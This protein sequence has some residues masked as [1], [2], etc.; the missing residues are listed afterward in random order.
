MRMLPLIAQRL[1]PIGAL[2]F[3]ALT[4]FSET[5]SNAPSGTT[6]AH[7]DGVLSKRPVTFYKDVIPIAQ[8]KCQ[9]CHR[10]EGGGPFPLVQ[11]ADFLPVIGRIEMAIESGRMP[12]WNLD[13]AV[14]AWRDNRLLST[15]Q[16]QIFLEWI[17]RGFP[18][19]N[20]SD[21]PPARTWASGW[22]IGEPDHVITIP[23]AFGIPSSGSLPYRY[24]EITTSF[25]EDRWIQAMEIRPTAPSV[26]HHA[27]VF[28]QPDD[29]PM[30]YEDFGLNGFFAAYG[31]GHD[32]IVYPAAF[33][34]RL[35][36]GAK[37]LI[38]L[39]YTPNGTAASDK[40]AIAFKFADAAPEFEVNT[41]AAASSDFLLWPL[42]RNQKV[43]AAYTFAD[44]VSI[45]GFAPHMHLRG[46]AMRYE[47]VS[48]DR[49]SSSL[50]LNLPK[51]D[52]HRQEEYFLQAPLDVPAGSVLR[53]T[54]IFDNSPSNPHNP[55]PLKFV[56]FG[57]QVEQEM[58]TGFFHY[59]VKNPELH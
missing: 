22:Q 4:L 57:H 59:A 8:D 52:F 25:P 12:P 9:S 56:R 5:F 35:P 3:T 55:A 11:Y 1:I 38:Q 49:N 26:V 32:G 41:A 27:L 20:P 33:A 29:A 15:V 34:K 37:L 47:L 51:F 46:Q 13:P 48:P 53:V 6:S 44:S 28:V 16:R 7:L 14:G 24:V 40:T 10:E 50:L 36:A 39:H 31:P 54:G 21:A 2:V 45:I 17:R 23:R 43:F 58:M 42:L 18:E 30:R 19:G